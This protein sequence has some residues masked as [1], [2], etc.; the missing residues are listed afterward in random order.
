M[1]SPVKKEAFELWK[2][3]DSLIVIQTKVRLSHGTSI[4]TIEK[5]ARFWNQRRIWGHIEVGASSARMVLAHSPTRGSRSSI[6]IPAYL[7]NI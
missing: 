3:Q 7:I 5:W 6:V 4:T 1:G 2:A